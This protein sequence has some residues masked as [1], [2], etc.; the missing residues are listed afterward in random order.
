MI[1]VPKREARRFK[2]VSRAMGYTVLP[3]C[4]L[5][6]AIEDVEAGMLSKPFTTCEELFNHLG[7]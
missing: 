6:E 3:T 4:E 2:A 7:I 1:R 5:D